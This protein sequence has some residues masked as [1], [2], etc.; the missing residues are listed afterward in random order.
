MAGFRTIMGEHMRT[1]TA[2]TAL[3]IIEIQ[4]VVADWGNE[5]D[6]HM[7]DN[8]GRDVVNYF[9]E[10]C[11]VDMGQVTYKG[12]EA[13]KKFY[14]DRNVRVRAQQKDG[15]RTQRHGMGQVRVVLNGKDRATATFLIINFSGEGR[16]PLMNPTASTTTPTI[17]TDVRFEMRKDK[18][19]PWRIEQFISRPI[20]I[21]NDP[22]LNAGMAP[23]RAAQ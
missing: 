7:S 1:F 17:V 8:D 19:K 21:G 6:F 9:T 2:E 15:V 16:P 10:D 14:A 3:D 22:F 4:Q 12:H 11:L 20:F 18:G 23:P 5:L 13:M